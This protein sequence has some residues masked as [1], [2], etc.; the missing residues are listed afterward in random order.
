MRT[1][2]LIFFRQQKEEERMWERESFM[3]ERERER[4]REREFAT[5]GTDYKLGSLAPGKLYTLE[6]KK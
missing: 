4:E 1:H 5:C 6:Q 3:W 2:V